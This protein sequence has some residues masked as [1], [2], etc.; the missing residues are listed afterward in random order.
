MNTNK[1]EEGVFAFFLK[2]NLTYFLYPWCSEKSTPSAE[3]NITAEKAY[4][5]LAHN[6][7]RIKEVCVANFFFH[8]FHS[9]F[10]LP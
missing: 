5:F 1:R 6:V 9:P 8:N 10:S 3:C 2:E 4:G 7:L